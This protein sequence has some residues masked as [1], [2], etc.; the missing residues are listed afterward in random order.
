[1]AAGGDDFVCGN[2]FNAALA[3]FSSYCY[4]ANASEAVEM[5]PTDEKDYHKCSL[6]VIVW[7]ATVY[8]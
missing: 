4:N 3:I 1:M 5:I 8:A 2:Y 6:Y 7:I